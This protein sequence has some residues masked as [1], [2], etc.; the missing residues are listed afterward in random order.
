MA[1]AIALLA[2]GSL[3]A[4][5]AGDGMSFAMQV[6]FTGADVPGGSQLTE[7]SVEAESLDT[8]G[9]LRTK[10]A[11]AVAASAVLNGFTAPNNRMSL[12]TFQK[13]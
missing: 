11:A 6:L 12:P 1:S 5:A 2:P 10:M 9:V 8:A 13:G 3:S 4:S 7:V